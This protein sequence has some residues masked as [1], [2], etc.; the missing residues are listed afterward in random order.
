MSERDVAMAAK[1]KAKKAMVAEP[2]VVAGVADFAL[3]PVDG[4][5]ALLR[6][7][8]ESRSVDQADLHFVQ[9]QVAKAIQYTY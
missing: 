2:V 4:A 8:Q 6:L 7:G 1:A 9:K 3:E 5:R